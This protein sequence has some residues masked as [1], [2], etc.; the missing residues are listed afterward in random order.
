MSS[1]YSKRAT[2]TNV[3]DVTCI[4]TTPVQDPLV[5][6]IY[7]SISVCSRVVHFLALFSNLLKP[8]IYNIHVLSS[9]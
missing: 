8:F 3:Q 4:H 7:Y 2:I 5:W 1:I 6:T 9:L